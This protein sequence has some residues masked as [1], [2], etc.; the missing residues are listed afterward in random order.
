MTPSAAVSRKNANKPIVFT[1][2]Q[3]VLFSYR[4]RQ[5]AQWV[6]GVIIGGAQIKTRADDLSG[7][8]RQRREPVGCCGSASQ[9]SIARLG[10]SHGV[11]DLFFSTQ[12]DWLE[13]AVMGFSN[14]ARRWGR[15]RVPIAH[16]VG[17]TRSLV[18]DGNRDPA[19]N[20]PCVDRL[21]TP[22]SPSLE[23]R[24]R[25]RNVPKNSTAR[26]KPGVQ[27]VLVGAASP[28]RIAVAIRCQVQSGAEPS[29]KGA[30]VRIACS[31]RMASQGG[32]ADIL[33]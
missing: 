12:T 26:G 21:S 13:F 23:D 5:P 15:R 1:V 6:A 7:E 30:T 31:V 27:N 33:E 3:R 9:G 24:R 17:A 16:V 20:Y 4:R 19:R 11:A 10:A 2:G 32:G 29:R 22:Q 28:I 14:L 8:A 25:A 18:G